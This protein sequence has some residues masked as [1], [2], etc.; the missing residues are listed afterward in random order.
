MQNRRHAQP[1]ALPAGYPP[2]HGQPQAL[3][4]S[5]VEEDFGDCVSVCSATTAQRDTRASLDPDL[6][7]LLVFGER[8]NTQARRQLSL[9]SGAEVIPPPSLNQS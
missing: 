1:Q 2:Q 5:V 7:R 3:P 6:Q 9:L 4:R 8:Q